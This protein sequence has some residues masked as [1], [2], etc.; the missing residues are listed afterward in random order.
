[1]L[2]TTCAPSQRSSQIPR[3]TI[4]PGSAL[5]ACTSTT[6][7]LFNGATDHTI[8][9]LSPSRAKFVGTAAPPGRLP[10][11]ASRNRPRT[12][13]LIVRPLLAERKLLQRLFRREFDCQWRTAAAAAVGFA[14]EQEQGDQQQGHRR[15]RKIE[16]VNAV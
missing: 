1:M 4:V 16:R 12:R 5:N 2:L 3:Y 6:S 7:P 8:D 10:T 15:E 14:F 13:E 9:E 11:R